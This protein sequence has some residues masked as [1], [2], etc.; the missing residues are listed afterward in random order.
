[1]TQSIR[2]TS[3]VD[4]YK[5]YPDFAVVFSGPVLDK[6][7]V[8]GKEG[9]EGGRDESLVQAPMVLKREIYFQ[10]HSIQS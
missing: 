3:D 4:T 1:M 6:G 8:D 2:A 7:R 10:T 9:Q 5:V